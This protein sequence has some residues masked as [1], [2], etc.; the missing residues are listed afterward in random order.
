MGRAL[1]S[2]PRSSIWRTVLNGLVQGLEGARLDDKR[3]K[4]SGEE[5]CEWGFESG[6]TNMIY[7]DPQ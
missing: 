7:G 5:A 3:K 1:S 4:S 2:I 6:V